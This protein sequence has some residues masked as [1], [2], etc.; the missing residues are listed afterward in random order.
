MNIKKEALRVEGSTRRAFD[1]E[2]NIPRSGDNWLAI[3]DGKK[4]NGIYYYN[5]DYGD[6]IDGI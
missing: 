2:S 4:N 3:T 5:G 6:D 1:C